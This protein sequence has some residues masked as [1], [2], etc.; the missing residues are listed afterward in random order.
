MAALLFA[1]RTVPVL[2]LATAGM[3]LL[4]KSKQKEQNRQH[5]N[6][7]SK[8]SCGT[9]RDWHRDAP[10]PSFSASETR[11]S[12]TASRL[13]TRND[14]GTLR[15]KL[16]NTSRTSCEAAPLNLK[17]SNDMEDVQ[18]TTELFSIPLYG[19]PEWKKQLSVPELCSH[20]FLECEDIIIK[21]SSFFGRIFGG[22]HVSEITL[23][24][25]IH[26][27]DVLG[28]KCQTATGIR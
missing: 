6:G 11:L 2:G 22:D 7:L 1:R 12:Q 16:F 20:P 15:S 27:S 28:R 9:P 21:D 13:G 17:E 14:S 10:T 24:G 23:L 25:C 4:S 26:G 5:F 3:S 19:I 18:A 8:S